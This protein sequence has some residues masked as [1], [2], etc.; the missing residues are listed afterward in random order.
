MFLDQVI[1]FRK[2]LGHQVKDRSQK[3][4]KL[5]M[6]LAYVTHLKVQVV[7]FNINLIFSPWRVVR[8]IYPVRKKIGRSGKGSFTE[9]GKIV[10]RGS[11]CSAPEGT[12]SKLQYEPILFFVA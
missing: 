4:L 7:S 12:V 11:I 8:Q 3:K 5:L 9:K 6:E 1:H 2:N 10:D